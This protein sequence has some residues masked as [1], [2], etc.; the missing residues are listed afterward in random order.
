MRT[1]L[2]RVATIAATTLALAS[3][4]Q[5]QDHNHDRSH[6]CDHKHDRNCAT[7][8]HRSNGDVVVRRNDVRVPP[9]LAKKPGGLPPGQLRKRWSTGDGPNALSDVFRRHGYRVDRIT[10]FGSS[11]YVYYRAPN[12]QLIRAIVSPGTDRLGFANVP[13]SLLQEVLSRLY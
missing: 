13:S 9:G 8:V 5:A 3:S 11:R 7:V 6:D 10:T 12:G 1:I 4:A 2:I